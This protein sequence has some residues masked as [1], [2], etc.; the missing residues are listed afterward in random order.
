MWLIPSHLNLVHFLNISCKSLELLYEFLCLHLS[1]RDLIP[2]CVQYLHYNLVIDQHCALHL[3][4]CHVLLCV[5]RLRN[6]LYFPLLERFHLSSVLLLLRLHSYELC[7]QLLH[8]LRSFDALHDW[9]HPLPLLK[10]LGS[11][12]YPFFLL[13]PLLDLLILF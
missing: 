10:A 3:N 12:A 2:E 1:L 4:L 5:F 8:I 13:V 7:L 6:D 11:C 9:H